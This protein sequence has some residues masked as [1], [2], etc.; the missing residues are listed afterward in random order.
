[1]QEI[2]PEIT[3][4]RATVPNVVHFGTSFPIIP[5]TESRSPVF[6]KMPEYDA[7]TE[8]VETKY[9]VID[10]RIVTVYTVKQIEEMTEREAENEDTSEPD[11]M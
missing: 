6:W 1:M 8:Y 11:Q 5:F 4:I 9:T 7:E 2:A 3:E 10:D